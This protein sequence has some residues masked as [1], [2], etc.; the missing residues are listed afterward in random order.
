MATEQEPGSGQDET[1][2]LTQEEL[3]QKI[4]D[5]HAEWQLSAEANLNKA[6]EEWAAQTAEQVKA[7]QTKA[8]Q[9]AKLSQEE[10]EAAEA[11]Q[12]N[13]ELAK[14]EQELNMREYRIEA[15]AQLEEQGL[16]TE[17]VDMVLSDDVDVTKGN[18]TA[19]KTAFDKAVE[20]TVT[21]KMK[22]DSI[23]KGSAAGEKGDLASALG[24]TK[25]K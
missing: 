12:R 25:E 21:E 2:T 16:S 17:F 15:S 6:K 5:A 10:R 8:E 19:L 1:V 7:A 18:I 22:G 3:D 14:R 23:R 20:V 13:D 11:Q 9:L 24:L 4:A